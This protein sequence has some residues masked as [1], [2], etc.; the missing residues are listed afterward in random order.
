MVPATIRISDWA[1]VARS[2]LSPHPCSMTASSDSESLAAP[3]H[4]PVPGVPSRKALNTEIAWFVDISTIGPV[5]ASNPLNPVMVN[6]PFEP[7]L[8]GAFERKVMVI[9]FRADGAAVL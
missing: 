6:A 4:Q 5:L 2:P 8:I 7:V 3:F 1:G 9:R